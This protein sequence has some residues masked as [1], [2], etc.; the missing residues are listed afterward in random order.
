LDLKEQLVCKEYRES[1]EIRV[2]LDR[3]VEMVFLEVKV[4]PVL[5][6]QLALQVHQEQMVLELQ[7][8]QDLQVALQELLDLQAL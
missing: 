7:V 1:K 6:E 4:Q 2:L 5:R 8:Q 3:Q